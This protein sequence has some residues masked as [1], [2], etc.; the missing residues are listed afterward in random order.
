MADS[1]NLNVRVSGALKTHVAR[2]LEHGEYE[3]VSEYV[4][5]LIRED[6][7]RAEAETFERMRAELALAFA[8]PDRAFEPLD[9]ETIFARNR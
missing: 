3:N 5:A 4:R 9:A 2:T 6:R 8:A 1:M 7:A